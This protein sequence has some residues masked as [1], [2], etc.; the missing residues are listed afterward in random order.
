M[1]RLGYNNGETVSY[2]WLNGYVGFDADQKPWVKKELAGLFAW[3]RRTQLTEYLPLLAL[4]K[5][6]V[7]KP[8]SEAELARDYEEIRR[9]ILVITDRAAPAAADLALALRPQQIASIEQKFAENNDKF[10]KE[11]LRGELAERQ[12]ARFKRSM[13]QAEIWFGNFSGEQERQIRLLSDARPMEDEIV[14]ADRMQR[15]AEMI[16]LLQRIEAEKPTREAT[17]A[18]IR[19]Y[20]SGAMDHFGHPEFQ[21]YAEKARAAQ[22]RMMAGIINS[23]TPAQKLHFEQAV[24]SWMDDF[25]TLARLDP[26]PAPQRISVN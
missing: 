26:P 22:M 1:A 7:H 21:A 24:Q 16:R 19:Q 9:R 18:L 13:K 8:V 14:L 17:V 10:R 20:V 3:H 25:E 2:F 5:K 23:T 15:Q 12:R 4:A 6:R 11:H